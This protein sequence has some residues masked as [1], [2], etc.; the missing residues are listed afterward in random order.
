MRRF[1]V[2]FCLSLGLGL[3]LQT[4]MLLVDPST[5]WRQIW[6]GKPQWCEPGLRVDA[7]EVL[8]GAWQSQRP[9][10]VFFGTSR[11]LAGFARADTEARLPGGVMNLGVPGAD[12]AYIDGQLAAAPKNGSLRRIWIGLDYGMFVRVGRPVPNDET[13]RSS[14]SVA[15]GA[16]SL[17]A[18][19][20]ALRDRD[21]C[22]TPARDKAGFE[23]PTYRARKFPL[24][25]WRSRFTQSERSIA[26]QFRMAAA[27]E[28][29]FSAQIAERQWEAL[30]RLLA[31]ARRDGVA[32]VLLVNP[33]HR[34]YRRVIEEAGLGADLL[35]W[36]QRLATLAGDAGVPL[37]DWSDYLEAD[38]SEADCEQG[39]DTCA[40]YDIN[41]VTPRV[42]SRLLATMLASLESS[43]T[44]DPAGHA[45]PTAPNP[46]R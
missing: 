6:P 10:D 12:V 16:K 22:R 2:G 41:H 3:A 43:P 30:D 14:W 5:Q 36:R 33:S 23:P 46:A 37:F 34:D 31:R 28:P 32:V 11:V 17:A 38:H 45:L 21:E 9:G 20:T 35:A 15:L 8:L 24:S 7:H 27:R 1:A 18:T 42:G 40:Y 44:D 4:L 39:S 19:W 26:T 25:G 13:A 29:E